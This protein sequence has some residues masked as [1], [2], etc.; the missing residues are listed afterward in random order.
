MK[1]HHEEICAMFGAL[2]RFTRDYGDLESL[3]YL[4]SERE[5]VA[6]DCVLVKWK[7]GYTKSINVNMDSEVAMLVDILKHIE[8]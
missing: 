8:D 6:F 4:S 2:L 7:N 5:D 3:E 1:E